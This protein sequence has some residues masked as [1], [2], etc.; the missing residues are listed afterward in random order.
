VLVTR[1]NALE[2]AGSTAHRY[3][4]LACVIDA[5][6]VAHV[7]VAEAP[8]E[9]LRLPLPRR[10]AKAWLWLHFE[11]LSKPDRRD[12]LEQLTRLPVVAGDLA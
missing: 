4:V 10:E 8:V 5:G 11:D 9:T 3:P 6:Q 7:E 2:I 12:A 1:H